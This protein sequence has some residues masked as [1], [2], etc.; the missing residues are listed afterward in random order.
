MRIR[1][2]H[3]YLRRPT[4]APGAARAAHGPAEVVV[5]TGGTASPTSAATLGR[6]AGAGRLRRR[7]ACGPPGKNSPFDPAAAEAST[8]PLSSSPQLRLC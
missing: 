3:A 5:A 1:E 7:R 6:A 8:V 2:G 4:S